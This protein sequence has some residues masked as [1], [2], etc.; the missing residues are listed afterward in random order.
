[1]RSSFRRSQQEGPDDQ[2]RAHGQQRPARPC[3][4]GPAKDR[5]QQETHQACPGASQESGLQAPE[6]HELRPA[7]TCA[8]SL[9]PSPTSTAQLKNATLTMAKLPRSQRGNR[10]QASRRKPTPMR[11]TYG[12]EGSRRAQRMPLSNTHMAQPVH[13]ICS[14]GKESAPWRCPPASI[15]A[16]S[17]PIALN[18]EARFKPSGLC[19]PAGS[20]RRPVMSWPSHSDTASSE[21]DRATS[22][23]SGQRRDGALP[24]SIEG[25]R[26][27]CGRSEVRSAKRGAGADA[28]LSLPAGPATI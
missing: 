6:V 22:W 8:S 27:A 9:F 23:R 28:G 1:M 14:T 3:G 17:N 21:R 26:A 5:G 20:R 2:G 10:P 4:Q 7:A 25:S 11:A 19:W 13:R 16:V 12:L 15:G 24:L 18:T